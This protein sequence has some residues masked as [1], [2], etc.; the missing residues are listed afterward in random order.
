MNKI[1]LIG[2][3]TKDPE[4]KYTTG[5]NSTP[6]I[7]FSLAVN[8][9]FSKDG[10]PNADFFNCVCFGKSAETIANFCQKGSQL[11]VVGR[12]ELGSYT[13]KDGVKVNTTSVMVEE[14][15]FV[16]SKAGSNANANN[17]N[18]S[19]GFMDIPGSDDEELP[20]S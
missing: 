1:S 13:N 18:N 17:N 7:N 4:L 5:A 14:F 3:L 11:G 16:G 12:V 6:F 2:R 20:F 15:D 19:S 8:R 10:Q 9:R